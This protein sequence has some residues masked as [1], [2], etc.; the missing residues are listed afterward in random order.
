MMRRYIKVDD[1]KNV[2]S[3][4]VAHQMMRQGSGAVA[5]VTTSVRSG[6]LSVLPRGIR[7][8]LVDCGLIVGLCNMMNSIIEHKELARRR[9]QTVPKDTFNV[10]CVLKIQ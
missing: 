7:S 4:L 3:S 6:R 5:V 10:P 8:N 1:T 2:C 9:V